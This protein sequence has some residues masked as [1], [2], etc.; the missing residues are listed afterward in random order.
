MALFRRGF[1][2]PNKDVVLVEDDY[3]G[4][5]NTSGQVG[6]MGWN[7]GAIAG[8]N[9]LSQSVVAEAN[10]YGI[11]KLTTGSAAAGNGIA[12]WLGNLS[13]TLQNLDTT[14]WDMF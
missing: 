3:L 12:M 7:F 1:F 13:N 11:A 10:H 4:G 2:A 6:Q 9:T 8:T 5:T 14:V